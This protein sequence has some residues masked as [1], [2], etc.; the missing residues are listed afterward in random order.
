[1]ASHNSTNGTGEGEKIITISEGR[2]WQKVP[3][4]KSAL[5]YFGGDGGGAL[6]S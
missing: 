3:R 4:E 6:K 5:K 2:K 1:M